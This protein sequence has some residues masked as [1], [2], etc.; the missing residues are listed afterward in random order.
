MMPALF[1]LCATAVAGSAP[2]S[3]GATVPDEAPPT[4]AA[5]I[6]A[7]SPTDAFTSGLGPVHR[8]ELGDAALSVRL[9]RSGRL[10]ARLDD[11]ST[12]PSSGDAPTR[13]RWARTWKPG[14]ALVAGVGGGLLGVGLALPLGGAVSPVTVPFGAATGVHVFTDAGYGYE[15]LGAYTGFAVAIPVAL[16][17]AKATGVADG[18]ELA[19]GSREDAAAAFGPGAVLV[20]VE[21]VTLPALGAWVAA[22]IHHRAKEKKIGAMLLPTVV[23][24]QSTGMSLAVRF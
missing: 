12:A 9:G 22:T 15:V 23:G 5:L 14:A 20:L 19:G 18:L 21:T 17:T 8:V 1:G 6:W 13:R 2:A 4:R 16:V 7:D 11:D 3:V 10:A 24:R